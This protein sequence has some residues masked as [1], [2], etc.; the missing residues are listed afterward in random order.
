MIVYVPFFY[1]IEAKLPRRSKVHTLQIADRHPVHIEE[2]EDTV[3]VARFPRGNGGR[4]HEVRYWNGDFWYTFTPDEDGDPLSWEDAKLPLETRASFGSRNFY[5]FFRGRHHGLPYHPNIADAGVREILSSTRA[6]DIEGI[7]SLA[8][9]YAVIDGLVYRKE[10][11]PVL[12]PS[13]EGFRELRLRVSHSALPRE[14]YD[15][16]S[17]W[18]LD[19]FDSLVDAYTEMVPDLDIQGVLPPEVYR[20]DLL[21]WN[22]DRDRLWNELEKA[23]ASFVTHYM[24]EADADTLMTYVE[25]RDFLR[26]ADR[27][28]NIQAER[29]YAL[30][31]EISR[32]FPDP[33]ISP[34][35]ACMRIETYAKMGGDGIHSLDSMALR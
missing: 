30:I 28:S 17:Y 3:L 14:V 24:A 12:K 7:E 20:P 4:P 16:A 29:A 27:D 13:L 8:S 9:N 18:R 11:E 25:L 26:S 6:K 23:L 1:K 21:S 31:Q 19:D 33:E 2:V 32:A 34:F 15:P 5:L 35:D 22:R 10:R